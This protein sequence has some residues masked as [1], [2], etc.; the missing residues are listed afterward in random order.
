MLK[1]F[2]AFIDGATNEFFS[3]W[4]SIFIWNIQQF[5][6]KKFQINTKLFSIVEKIDV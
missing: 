6:D 5:E 3:Y 1:F 4:L 2:I